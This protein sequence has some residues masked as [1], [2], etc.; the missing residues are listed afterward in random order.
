[1]VRLPLASIQLPGQIHALQHLRRC[2]PAQA[3]PDTRQLSGVVAHNQQRVIDARPASP[4]PTGWSVWRNTVQHSR[5][6]PRRSRTR[7]ADRRARLAHR[8]ARTSSTNPDSCSPAVRPKRHARPSDRTG[9]DAASGQPPLAECLLGAPG[10]LVQRACRR[11]FN[12]Q[13]AVGFTSEN[14]RS[15][16]AIS[17]STSLSSAIFRRTLS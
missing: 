4:S 7:L 5:H 12:V 17:G 10:G 11:R 1:M 8:R 9:S 3:Q 6:R 14:S 2:T 13:F 15:K 16:R